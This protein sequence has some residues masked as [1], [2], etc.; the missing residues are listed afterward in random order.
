MLRNITN[1]HEHQPLLREGMTNYH[2]CGWRGGT[3]K[4]PAVPVDDL[5]VVP[6]TQVG[7][8]RATCVTAALRDLTPTLQS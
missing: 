2:I 4:V 1:T 3:V 5:S 8:L 7:Q 6:S